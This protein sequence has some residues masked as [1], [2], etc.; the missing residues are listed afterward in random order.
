MYIIINVMSLKGG[1]AGVCM[2]I[3]KKKF[4]KVLKKFKKQQKSL[5]S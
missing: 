3:F 4:K 2:E 1:R 5:K